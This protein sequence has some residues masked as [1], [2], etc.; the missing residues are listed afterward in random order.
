[1]RTSMRVVGVALLVLGLA[2]CDRAA[3][4]LAERAAEQVT[5][6]DVEL[7]E[8]GVSIETDEGSMSVNEDGELTMETDDGT[9]ESRT[10]Q[11]PDDFPSVVPLLDGGELMAGT[12]IEDDEN[13]VVWS[14]SWQF[15]SGDPL[16]A[17][18]EHVQV[19][20]DA[21]FTQEEEFSSSTGEGGM[22]GVV[23]V[24]SG[25]RVQLSSLGETDDFIVGYQVF[26]D[27]GEG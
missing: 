11:V 16:T 2:A 4:E 1:M 12:R 24:G 17:L 15:T 27:R 3:E 22:A 21:G 8:D 23:M 9:F 5:G 10:G 19:M 26:E 18:D 7:G 20:E 6:G 13:G 14:V 25:Y